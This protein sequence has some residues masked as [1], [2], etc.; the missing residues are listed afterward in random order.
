VDAVAA[1]G[2]HRVLLLKPKQGLERLDFVV[3]DGGEGR[4]G[5]GRV[6]L[7][8]GAQHFAHDEEVR[9]AADGVG[10]DAGGAD[11]AVRVV[12]FGLARGGPVVGPVA[13]VLGVEGLDGLHEALGLG[14][15]LVELEAL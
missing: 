7:A 11:D 8:V 1:L 10:H 9:G 14:A 12:A 15:H 6:G 3:D 4:A 5:V 13:K 2:N